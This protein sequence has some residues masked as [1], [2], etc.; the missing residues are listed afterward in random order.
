MIALTLRSPCSPLPVFFALPP[1]TQY[2]EASFYSYAAYGVG[3]PQ[4]KNVTGGMKANLTAATQAYAQELATDELLHVEFLLKA[5]GASSV[6]CP[7]LDLG[8]AFS[9]AANA[10][11]GLTLSPSYSPYYSDSWFL[12]G[13]FIFEVSS[14]NL[15]A[16]SRAQLA[17]AVSTHVCSVA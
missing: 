16:V 6:P 10:A 8:P 17:Q 7:P 9:A 1:H 13:A 14:C 12:L 4:C 2:L 11:T 3:I 15:S 5:L